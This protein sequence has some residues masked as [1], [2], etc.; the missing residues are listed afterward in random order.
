IAAGNENLEPETSD[1]WTVGLVW[2]PN[3]DGGPAWIEGITTSLDFYNLEIDD[4]IQG[5]DPGDV[6][7]AC[8]LTLD[9]LFCTLTPRTSS[10][11]LDVVNNQL[12]NIGGIETSGV[13]IA[14]MYS[15]PET[16]FGQFNAQ[17]NASY[18]D[19]YTEITAN[20]DDTETVTD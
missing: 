8:V 3:L 6:I 18:L 4:A 1:H 13:D 2:T 20:I 9:P 11:Q 16:S 15:G 10:G 14:I 19:E 7:T 12:Q 17:F 5:R